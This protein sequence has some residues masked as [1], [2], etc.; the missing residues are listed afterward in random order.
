MLYRQAHVTATKHYFSLHFVWVVDNVQCILVMHACVCLSLCLC[1]GLSLTTF[2]HYCTDPDVTWGNC[3]GCPL[4]V[5]YWVDLQSVRGFH[6]YDNMVPKA[7]CQ[8]VLV[9]ALCL[10]VIMAALRS[11]CE[12]YIFMLS[13]MLSVFPRLISAIAD[14]MSAIFPHMLWP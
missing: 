8:W 12:H 6:C 5:H 11:R 1:V 2:P 7:K 4:V 10:I 3:R 9:L 13:F 14:W